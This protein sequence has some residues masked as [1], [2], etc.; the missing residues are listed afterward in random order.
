[1]GEGYRDGDA[2][3]ERDVAI[4]V[5]PSSLARDPEWMARFER[6]ARSVGQLS[7]P[8]I[9]NIFEFGRAALPATDGT[10]DPSPVSYAV[11]ELLE[12]EPLRARRV[13]RSPFS[14]RE[15]EEVETRVLA[16]REQVIGH[17]VAISLAR[18]GHE[19]RDVDARRS[20]A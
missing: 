4:K 11:M 2:A 16:H 15:V 18:L 8:N 12:G 10:S 19:V 5:L 17:R 7:H 20:H 9:L 6:E 1:M 13:H 3:L 14:S